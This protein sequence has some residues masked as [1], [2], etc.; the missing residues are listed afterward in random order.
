MCFILGQRWP[1]PLLSQGEECSACWPTWSSEPKQ[2]AWL[3][4]LRCSSWMI[5]SQGD[6]VIHYK[7]PAVFIFS[8]RTLFTRFLSNLTSHS[9]TCYVQNQILTIVS[10][11]L[12]FLSS[13]T[14][15]HWRTGLQLQKNKA[16]V[17]RSACN[18]R[19][20]TSLHP[21]ENQMD[22]YWQKGNVSRLSEGSENEPP[23]HIWPNSMWRLANTSHIYCILFFSPVLRNNNGEVQLTIRKVKYPLCMFKCKSGCQPQDGFQPFH[24]V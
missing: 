15:R 11:I 12:M 16:S 7:Q 3:W 17:L 22:T 6:A 2:S 19:S 14:L 4:S 1:Q 23:C 24:R 9:F 8:N 5:H 13:H 10:R 18:S 20:Q 21:Q